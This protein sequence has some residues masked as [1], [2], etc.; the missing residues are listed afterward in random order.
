MKTLGLAMAINFGSQIPLNWAFS[1]LNL[2]WRARII[3]AFILGFQA[4]RIATTYY[5]EKA[6]EIEK[7]RMRKMRGPPQ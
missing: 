4:G 5:R 2:D 7:V 3:I 6:L 1:A